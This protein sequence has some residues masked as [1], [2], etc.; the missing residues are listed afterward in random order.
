MGGS[1]AAKGNAIHCDDRTDCPTGLVCCAFDV[2]NGSSVAE[3][4]TLA[5]CNGPKAQVLCDP[6]DPSSCSASGV[7]GMCTSGGATIDGYAHCR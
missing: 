3:C 7:N 2:P 1:C 5:T 4:R 6:Q